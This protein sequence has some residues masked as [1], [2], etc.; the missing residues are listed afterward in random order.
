MAGKHHHSV[1]MQDFHTWEESETEWKR[2]VIVKKSVL[3]DVP[4]STHSWSCFFVSVSVSQIGNLTVL[5][6]LCPNVSQQNLP[7]HLVNFPY[8]RAAERDSCCRGT[9]IKWRT[10]QVKRRLTLTSG[11]HT[12]STRQHAPG[13]VHLALSG[14]TRRNTPAVP[15]CPTCILLAKLRKCLKR[16]KWGDTH[17]FL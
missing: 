4:A 7:L 16:Y 2:M 15:T 9:Q 3:L 1:T 6:L 8:T 5:V 17:H 12:P 10:Q 13:H 14:F 11:W